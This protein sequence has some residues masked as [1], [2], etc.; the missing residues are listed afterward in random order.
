MG[1]VYQQPG[2]RGNTKRCHHVQAGGIIGMSR[3]RPS[4]KQSNQCI[5]P[6]LP[7]ESTWALPGSP[8]SVECIEDFKMRDMARSASGTSEAPGKK[9]RVNSRLNSSL[10]GQGWSEFRRRLEYKLAWNGGWLISVVPQNTSRT[11]PARLSSEWCRHAA[12]SRN[13]PKQLSEAYAHAQVLVESSV[14]RPGRMS[15]KRRQ[16]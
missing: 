1:S 13:P 3:F 6:P 15:I 10:L 11:C 12:S 7:W 5:H 8:P 16:K 9:L 14:F 2:D 4:G